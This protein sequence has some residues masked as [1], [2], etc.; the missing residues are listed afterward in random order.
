MSAT[1]ILAVFLAFPTKR[2]HFTEMQGAHWSLMTMLPESKTFLLQI[3]QLCL[4]HFANVP[5]LRAQYGT[6][7]PF[8]AVHG[9]RDR[10]DASRELALLFPSF[11]FSDQVPEAAQ[12]KS[13]RYV[14]SLVNL[15]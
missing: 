10:E 11:K 4:V 2:K 15:E 3:K 7:M 5:S 9:S 13:S 6:E 14:W 12:G 1:I 8:N